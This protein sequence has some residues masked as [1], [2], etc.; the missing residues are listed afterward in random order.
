MILDVIAN[1]L[2]TITGQLG[3]ASLWA[4]LEDPSQSGCRSPGLAVAHPTLGQSHVGLG[5]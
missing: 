1:L 4:D 5:E 3:L 2:E